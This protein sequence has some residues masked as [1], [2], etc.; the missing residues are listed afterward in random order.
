MTAGP[1]GSPE[2]DDPFGYLYRNEGAEQPEPDAPQPGT[3]RTSY[4]QV[5]R[6][7]ERRPPQQPQQ[8]Q[9]GYGY[10]QQGQQQPGGY[11]YPPQQQQQPG[12][13][14]YPPQQGQPQQYGGQQQPP[15]DPPPGGHRGG[16]RQDTPNR[17]GLLIGAVA[18][19]AAVAIGIAFAMTNGSGDD[20]KQADDKS[21]TAPVTATTPSSRPTPSATPSA[22]DSKKVDASTLTLAG[23]AATS[24]QWPGADA[25]GGVYVDS[26]GTP[27]ATVGWTVTVPK[28]GPYT[29]FI[30]YGNA[31]DDAKLTLAVN[32]QPRTD[33]VNLKNY[34]QPR[35]T[36]WSKAWSNLTYAWVDLQKGANVLSLT[37]MPNT[38][39]GVNLDQVWLKQNQ[40]TQ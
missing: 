39:C 18:V 26:L 23:G 40:V 5:Q 28:A 29:F 37:C 19:V 1:D 4:N 30:S 8:Y 27:G 24:T 25:A 12:G 11:G 34:G 6:V 21:T 35:Y 14:G 7:G 16:D 15:Y 3:P 9:G 32:G 33:G 10:P 2:N 20:K 13:Y 36:D 22:F 31:G 17:K 38:N